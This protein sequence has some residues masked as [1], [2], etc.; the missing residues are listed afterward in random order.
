MNFDMFICKLSV[1]VKKIKVMHVCE[2]NV[3]AQYIQA[4][5]HNT[6]SYSVC[7]L[8]AVTFWSGNSK[9]RAVHILVQAGKCHSASS[10]NS[11]KYKPLFSKCTKL[12]ISQCSGPFLLLARY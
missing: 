9:Y 5:K 3:K 7:S 8:L 12:C 11:I 1:Y 2:E 4:L 6:A 10:Q